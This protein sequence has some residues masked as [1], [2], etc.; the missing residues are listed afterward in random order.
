MIREFM[1]HPGAKDPI[2]AKTPPPSTLGRYDLIFVGVIL[3]LSVGLYHSVLTQGLMRD[4]FCWLSLAREGLSDPSIVFSRFVSG[5]FR[6]VVHLSFIPTYA[7]FAEQ[8]WP[9]YATN[10]L[11]DAACALLVAWLALLLTRSRV[12][13]C[14]AAVMFITHPHHAEVV[15]WVSARTS[16]LMAM[17]SLLALIGWIR[18]RTHGTRRW[19][20]V[21]TLAF[22]AALG[23][24]EEA[25]ILLLLIVLLEWIAVRSMTNA[26][27]MAGHRL[28]RP[29]VVVFAM[30]CVIFAAYL[31]AQY[32]FQSAN[33]IVTGGG[34]S[35]HREG[36]TRALSRVPRLFIH[37]H[38]APS[39]W[40]VAS[41]LL[42]CV[43]G[44]VILRNAT[45][46]LRRAAIFGL[47]LAFVAVLPTSFFTDDAYPMRYDYLATGGSAIA[48]GAVVAACIGCLRELRRLWSIRMVAYALLFTFGMA[49]PTQAYRLRQTLRPF[50]SDAQLGGRVHAAM[51]AI[52][53][54]LENARNQKVGVI[55]E[56]PPLPPLDMQCLCHLVGGIPREVVKP[57]YNEDAEKSPTTNEP[58]IGW[59]DSSG[60]FFA[61]VLGKP[62]G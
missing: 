12:A 62:A 1:D 50:E 26:P 17:F 54:E 8:A 55:L 27:L 7:V 61:E 45:R 13:A 59:R 9:Y 18:F 6:P 4:D 57:V 52:A 35:L 28:R 5:F 2:S 49:I 29:A 41:F 32:A 60:Q 14:V 21:T 58:R 39:A 42:L 25:A 11:L 20:V 46:K 34:F 40:A 30:C 22:A 16:S 24:K 19:A 43:F 15:A 53:P 51:Q 3:L 44:A 47:S 33:P 23:S 10:L 48:W 37:K 31:A 56:D 36:F 38:I